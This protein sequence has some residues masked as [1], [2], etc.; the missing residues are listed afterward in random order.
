[1][2]R[3]I[4][5]TA[6]R[7]DRHSRVK[8][9]LPDRFLFVARSIA[10]ATLL[11]GTPI[12]AQPPL[13]VQ[14]MSEISTQST[15]LSGLI[16][17]STGKIHTVFTDP[18]GG[19]GVCNSDE[20]ISVYG[21]N[22]L[23]ILLM[24][25]PCLSQ[26]SLDQYVASATSTGMSPVNVLNVSSVGNPNH[27]HIFSEIGV[28]QSLNQGPPNDGYAH[29]YSAFADGTDLYIGGTDVDC[30]PLPGT[31]YKLGS[32]SW[33]TCMPASINSFESSGDSILAIHYPSVFKLDRMTG[34]LGSSFN[35][36][37]GPATNTGKTCLNGDSLYWTIVVNGFTHVGKYVLEQGSEWEQVLPYTSPPVGLELDAYGRLWTAVG[38]N[39]IW[40]NASDGSYDSAIQGTVIRTLDMQNG[41][42]VI[43]GSL[44]SILVFIMKAIP[45][46]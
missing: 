20:N 19:S 32:P 31:V 33:R 36:F 13:E 34:A 39:L 11:L 45:T 46:P 1:M 37:T 41:E 18:D 8:Q 29:A 27:S 28:I 6:D 3:I 38:N 22:G 4:Q 25:D 10:C 2:V 42:L 24:F 35:L 9:L 5:A 15:I 40:M 21:P 12:L 26:G 43:T 7:S 16:D 14:W 23:P 30:P 44:N 17:P